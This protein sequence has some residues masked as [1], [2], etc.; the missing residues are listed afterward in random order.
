MYRKCTCI[1]KEYIKLKCALHLWGLIP[2]TYQMYRYFNITD[3]CRSIIPE[4]DMDQV[5]TAKKSDSEV[6]IENLVDLKMFLLL[7]CQGSS[8]GEIGTD[9]QDLLKC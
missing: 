3:A 4:T 9:Y 1:D 5:S 7:L 2:Q 8:K 6:D